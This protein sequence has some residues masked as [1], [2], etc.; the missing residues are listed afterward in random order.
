MQLFKSRHHTDKDWQKYANMNMDELV[1]KLY[2]SEAAT[3]HVRQGHPQ[4][5]FINTDPDH[6]MS[7]IHEE[8]HSYQCEQMLKWGITYFDLS[9]EQQ[10]LVDR[11]LEK[12]ALEVEY[13]MGKRSGLAEK[14]L[15][16]IRQASKAHWGPEQE[17]QYQKNADLHNLID[18]VRLSPEGIQRILVWNFKTELGGG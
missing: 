13:E 11:Y 6:F 7:R 5:L 2:G 4:K 15:E 18:T 3:T 1:L 14:S 17:S 10:E 16:L 9:V 8:V 12:E